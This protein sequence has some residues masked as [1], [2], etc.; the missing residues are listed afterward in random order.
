MNYFSNFQ[1]GKE[2]LLCSNIVKCVV[3][4]FHSHHKRIHLANDETHIYES[5]RDFGYMYTVYFLD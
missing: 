5:H 1:V 2:V 4:I 3:V